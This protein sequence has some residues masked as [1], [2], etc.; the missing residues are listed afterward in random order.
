MAIP[1]IIT[2]PLV[3]AG[4]GQACMGAG[5]I[6]KAN[7]KLQA[8]ELENQ[9]NISAFEKENKETNQAMDAVGKKE[10]YIIK[11]FEKFSELIN[12]IQNKPE[13]KEYAKDGVKLPKYDPKEI[14][15]VSVG[16]GVLLGGLGG[17]ALGIAGGFAA[18][19][20]I[21]ASVMVFGTASTGVQIAS[22]SGAAAVNATLAAI[23]GGSIAS[24]GGGIALGTS[25]LGAAA[26]GVAIIIGGIIFNVV[27]SN[28][29]NKADKAYTEM[30]RTEQEIQGINK[31]L[32]ELRTAARNYQMTLTSVENKY[33]IYINK[34]SEILDRKTNY[35]DFTEEE[36]LILQNTVLLVTLLYDMCK[37]QLVLKGEKP[38]INRT[39]IN[40]KTNNSKKILLDMN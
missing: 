7:K 9:Q 23:G 6:S 30:K 25:I 5:K 2:I 18:A 33:R 15:K 8:A 29:S 3:A 27:G 24:G 39:E 22:L 1:L 37:V 20:A 12:R 35:R 32:K 13:F 26:S 11:N 21:T 16:A 17:A 10:L 40:E 34:L 38:Q 4:L 19:G 31:Y 28:I 36:R 14:E